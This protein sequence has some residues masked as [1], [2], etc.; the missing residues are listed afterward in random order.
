MHEVNN[1]L[2]TIA[3]CAESLTLRLDDLRAAGCEVPTQTGEYLRII[4][5]EVHR[6]KR[7]VDGLLDFS[8]PKRAEQVSTDVNAVIEQA[9]FLVKHH[10]R[11]KKV[12][13][14]T[15]L[16][17]ELAAISGSTEQ[18][19]QVVMA[20][21]INAGDAMNDEGVIAVRTRRGITPHEAVLIEVIDEGQGIAR[22]DLPKIFEPFFT[23]KAPGRGT[24]LGLS[25]CYGI[26][27]EHG[28]RI[29][30]DS[31]PGAGSTF[32]VLLPSVTDA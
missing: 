13:L 29:E 12:Q 14:Q 4:D 3:A 25:I 8:R 15:L 11:F 7:I 24:G 23:T 20:L 10:A 32:R 1:P 5:N 9:V 26:I 19:I 6:C 17:P 2:A 31:A 22:S 18:L 30:V 16:E 27:A 21:L 28:G